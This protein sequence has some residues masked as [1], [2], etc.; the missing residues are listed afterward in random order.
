[1]AFSWKTVCVV[2]NC[3]CGN[4]QLSGEEKAISWFSGSNEKLMVRVMA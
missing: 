3:M 4:W 2:K 1:M